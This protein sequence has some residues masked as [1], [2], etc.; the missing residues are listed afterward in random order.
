MT[1]SLAPED[2]LLEMVALLRRPEAGRLRAMFAMEL[3]AHTF[4]RATMGPSET[5]SFESLDVSMILDRLELASRGIQ[6]L[7]PGYERFAPQN[8]DETLSPEQRRTRETALRAV[9]GELERP[10][11]RGQ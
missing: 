8:R 9:G 10:S 4:L 1:T 6:R 7:R 2:T 3:T 5:G 11:A